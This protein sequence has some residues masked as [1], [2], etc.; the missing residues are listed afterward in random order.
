MVRQ[1]IILSTVLR[2]HLFL[3]LSCVFHMASARP[4]DLLTE[5]RRWGFIW[6]VAESCRGVARE[7]QDVFR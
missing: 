2:C 5:S 6:E 1:D 7:G 4:V 3:P